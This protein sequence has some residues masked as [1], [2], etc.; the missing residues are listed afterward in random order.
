[1]REHSFDLFTSP[2]IDHFFNTHIHGQTSHN[3]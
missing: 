1:M 2:G 3:I